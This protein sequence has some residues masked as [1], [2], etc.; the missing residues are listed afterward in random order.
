MRRKGNLPWCGSGIVAALFALVVSFTVK[1]L[2]GLLIKYRV[3]FRVRAALER[4][5]IDLAEHGKAAY[6]DAQKPAGRSRL[7]FGG[8][9]AGANVPVTPMRGDEGEE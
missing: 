4:E 9:G 8:D 5:S 7:A 3:G 1:L 2:I 6:E